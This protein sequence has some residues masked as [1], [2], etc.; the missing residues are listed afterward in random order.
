MKD[1]QETSFTTQPPVKYLLKPLRNEAEGRIWHQRLGYVGKDAIKQLP[2]S[3]MGAILKG[4]TTVECKSCGVS[5]AHKVILRRQ[6]TQS[7]VPFYRIHLDLIPGIVVYNGNR[8][9][10][11]FLDNTT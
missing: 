11:H 10:V 5:K 8:H 9:V 4:P 6:P 7:S 1:L 2:Q 3:V